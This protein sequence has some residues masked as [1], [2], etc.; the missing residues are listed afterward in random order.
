[1]TARHATL[2]LIGVALS[3]AQFI[4]IRDFVSILYGEEIVIV[5]VTS[6]FFLGLSV[7][8]VLSLR[9][10]AR[11][12]RHLFTA[13]VFLHLT[14][15]FSYRVLAAMFADW[16]LGGPS[17]LALLVAYALV[18][19][20]VFASFLPRLVSASEDAGTA[21]PTDTEDARLRRYYSLELAGFMAGFIV[22]ALSW[23]RPSIFLLGTYWLILGFLLQLVLKRALWTTAFAAIAVTALS[24]FDVVDRGSTALLYEHK[25]SVR[26]PQV[27][28]SVNSPYQKVEVIQDSRGELYLYLDGLLNLNSTDLESLNYYLASLPAVLV[29]PEHALV[30]GNG[31]LSSVPKVYPHSGRVTSVELDGAVL[32]AGRRYF[33]KPRSLEKL[34]RWQLHVDD[35]RH[36]LRTTDERYDLIIVDVPSPLTIQEGALHT[37]EFYD[38]VKSRLTEQ[39]VIAVQLSGPLQKNDRTPARVA[40]ALSQVFPEVMAVNSDRADR[41]FAYASRDLPFNGRQVRE[42]A[43]E[44]ERGLELIRPSQ[45]PRFVEEATPLSIDR[46]DLVLRRGWARFFSRY[47]SG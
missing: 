19:N 35:G 20:L 18:F 36:F 16:D 17:F 6:T 47:L 24:F 44:Y 46:M 3:I 13:S 1:V 34:D 9:L 15:P 4:M 14:F 8:Y 11:A 43:M 39:G 27:L 42:A 23:N 45:V 5:I 30:I 28:Y 38:L 21:D 12:F 26:K 33:T 7:G 29:E 10:S 2:F 41:G 25:H 31:T 32:E 37:V 22:V 40:G